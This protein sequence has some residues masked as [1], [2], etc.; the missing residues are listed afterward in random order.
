VL[1]AA[2]ASMVERQLRG[3]GIDDERVLTA[4]ATVPRHRFVDRDLVGR[5]YADEALPS[6][7]GQTISQPLMVAL[8]TSLLAAEPSMRVLEIGTGTGYQ[9]AILATLGCQVTSIERVA[10]LAE[11]AR[12]RLAGLG[13][14]DAVEIRVADGSLGDSAGA[15][16]ERI[17]V[18]AGAP[19]IPDPLVAQLAEGGRL[20][21]PVGTRRKQSLLLVERRG[22]R[23]VTTDHGPCVFVPLVGEGG[24]T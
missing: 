14:G 7:F 24:W 17:L 10:G 6:A 19:R 13:L 15:P 8:M 21:V 11:L 5:A 20:V 22:G 16:W 4:M 9:A 12:A 18:T 2:R 1:E 23:V 3:R